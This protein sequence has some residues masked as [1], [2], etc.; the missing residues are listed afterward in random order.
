MRYEDVKFL[1]T[2]T[3][4]LVILLVQG[5][6]GGKE[7]TRK[8]SQIKLHKTAS[9]VAV[10]PLNVYQSTHSHVLLAALIFPKCSRG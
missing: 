1:D 7:T 8:I 5:N 10:E 9:V 2:Y 4:F 3:A 6:I